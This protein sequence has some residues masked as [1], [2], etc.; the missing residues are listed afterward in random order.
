[1]LIAS[2]STTHQTLLW[3]SAK[4]QM[5]PCSPINFEAAASTLA[6]QFLLC[7]LEIELAAASGDEY[8]AM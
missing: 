3:V 7:A 1:M 8:V 4:N 6:R 5:H 2:E